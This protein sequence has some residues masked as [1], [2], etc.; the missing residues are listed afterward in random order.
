MEGVEHS[1]VSWNLVQ[2]HVLSCSV[3]HCDLW[4]NVRTDS[5]IVLVHMYRKVTSS[6]GL[7]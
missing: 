2:N 3:R 5:H 1:V 7:G 6:L 4:Q